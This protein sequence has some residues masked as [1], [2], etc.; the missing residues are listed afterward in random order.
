MSGTDLAHQAVSS[1]SI[2]RTR[3][4]LLH[5]CQ[6]PVQRPCPVLTLSTKHA[7]NTSPLRACYAM[8]GAD[9]AH[10]LHV[11]GSG[12]PQ[13]PYGRA[14]GISL[15]ARS[16][17]AVLTCRINYGR[18]DGSLRACYAKPGTDFAVRMCQALDGINRCNPMPGFVRY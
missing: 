17:C 4:Q 2:L 11:S 10:Q 6:L 14:P 9:L 15:C 16:R 1:A 7:T 5:P 12:A 18:G 13:H 3:S 8:S